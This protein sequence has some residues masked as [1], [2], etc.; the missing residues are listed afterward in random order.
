ML[1]LVDLPTRS[2]LFWE[3]AQGMMNL[4]ERGGWWCLEGREEKLLSGCNIWENK[5]KKTHTHKPIH[6]HTQAHAHAQAHTHT[7]NTNNLLTRSTISNKIFIVSKLYR[8]E[9]KA[10]KESD[11]FGDYGWWILLQAFLLMRPRT[12]IMEIM[13]ARVKPT[14]IIL[15][16]VHNSKMSPNDTVLHTYN[17]ASLKSY[18]RSFFFQNV[19]FNTEV[20]TM[21]CAEPLKH[22]VLKEM[23]IISVPQDPGVCAEIAERS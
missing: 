14:T 13:I 7:P 2:V 10:L 23:Y 21:K 19:V 6:T 17:G 12:V 8:L 22:S 1:C 11:F 20:Q 5:R 9:F 16:S 15:Q 3:E 18:Q 4:G